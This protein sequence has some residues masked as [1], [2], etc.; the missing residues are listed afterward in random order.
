MS[1]RKYLYAALIAAS[2]SCLPAL[3]QNSVFTFHLPNN[4]VSSIAED[5]DGFIWF[6]TSNGL[7][8]Y[9]GSNCLTFYASSEEYDIHNDNIHALLYDRNNKTLW[10]GS[11]NGLI[12]FKDSRFYNPGTNV[13]NPVIRVQRL[14]NESLIGTG[15]DGIVKISSDGK[16]MGRLYKP[17]MSWITNICVSTIGE[18]WFTYPMNGSIR[19]CV[20][21]KDLH[22]IKEFV[23]ENAD[24]IFCQ[25]SNPD[26]TVWVAT[27]K[28]ILSYNAISRMP[29]KTPETVSSLCKGK[30]IKFISPYG[31]DAVLI[32]IGREGMYLY[33]FHK[34]SLENVYHEQR[35]NAEHY[36]CF[37][38][39]HENIWLSDGK[40]KPLFYP[41]SQQFIHLSIPSAPFGKFQKILFDKEGIMWGCTDG[42]YF[43][44]DPVNGDVLWQTEEKSGYTNC[45]IDSRN[46]LW[47]ISDHNK[48]NRYSISGGLARLKDTYTFQ[49]DISALEE[50]GDGNIWICQ[51]FECALFRS[52]NMDN[53]KLETV[54][55]SGGSYTIPIKDSGS[56]AV[57]LHSIGGDFFK[58]SVNGI[59]QDKSLSDIGDICCLHTAKDGNLWIGTFTNGLVRYNPS[60]SETTRFNTDNGLV[61]SYIKAIVEDPDGNIWF[62]SSK[63]ITKID[64]ASNRLLTLFDNYSGTTATY[65]ANCAGIS[66][67]GTLYFG[68][69][70]G[71]TAVNFKAAFDESNT[72]IPLYFQSITVQGKVLNGIPERIV[73]K[74]NENALSFL[75]SGLQFQTGSLLNY[76][77]KLDGFD[78]DWTY[79]TMLQR[80]YSSLPPGHYTFKVKVRL[81]NGEWSQYELA[82]PVRVK[83]SVWNSLASKIIYVLLF[84]GL[85]LA[86]IHIVTLFNIKNEKIK[87][88]EEKEEISRSHMDFISNISHEIRTPL[89]LI[90]APMKELMKNESLSS[91]DKGLLS[92]MERNAEILKSLS[93]KLL[94]DS[95]QEKKK[96]EPL[97]VASVNLS[98]L[99]LYSTE[100]FKYAAGEKD[101]DIFTNIMEGVSGYADREKVEKILY[102]FLSNALKYTPEHGEIKVS[103]LID[104]NGKAVFS[105]ADNGVGVPEEKRHNLFNRFERLGIE[106]TAPEIEGH[107]IGLNYSSYLARLHKGE[108]SFSPNDPS[109]SVFTLSIPTRKSN[110]SDEEILDFVLKRKKSDMA[111]DKPKDKDA[112]N[113]VIAEDNDDVRIFL[114]EL[115]SPQF[116]VT[117]CSNGVEAIKCISDTIPDLVLCDI[118]M[119]GKDGFAVCREIK[120][121][122]NYS[123]IP[124]ILLTA[125]NDTVTSVNS[126]RAGADSFI[127]KPFDPDYLTATILAL[128]NNR[129][130]LQ[131]KILNLTS[132]SI[133]E[134]E[135]IGSTGLSKQERAFLEKLH[136]V[137]DEHIGDENFSVE[138]LSQELAV[139][140]SSL[141]AKVKALTGS[142]PLS[143]LNTY[144]MNVAMELLQSGDYTVA[145]VADHVGSSTPFNFS[146]D[147]KKHFG[148]TPS[149]VKGV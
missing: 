104:D 70:E 10:I 18:I 46:H 109:G 64:L 73:L 88:A 131:D 6:A 47:T 148:V 11:E 71:M 62:S 81:M 68:T 57:F 4:D 22:Q 107:G 56:G 74:H 48:V 36:V 58:C 118:L 51:S 106:Q 114:R 117:T 122:P 83:P 110:Y 21:D 76:A 78:K 33:D 123:H 138:S 30:D 119:P 40:G 23:L 14:D 120:D 85:L 116:N 136:K 134:K 27:D 146:R 12:Y 96:E 61:D 97:K 53:G 91:H 125:K 59:K 145:E 15:R 142:S 101:I 87:L 111:E 127:Q 102:N 149:S 19:L 44:F 143:Y 41:Y 42:G 79:T 135:S 92:M 103:L 26:N 39:S 132:S 121:N 126:M 66:A 95:P 34:K 93:G 52:E 84:I 100:N 20:A 124:V 37:V 69:E 67:D 32:G 1:L 82:L 24:N 115:L 144:R 65:Q 9:S 77:C 5:S 141:Y 137:V 8:R 98:N 105:V 140:Y 2:T 86:L 113:I 29:I 31:K 55:L 50:D 128:I 72:Q 133:E 108:I 35:L 60:T 94:D 139:S 130:R 17:G 49:H 63:N 13:L 90:Y 80:T 75:Y 16:Y 45:L 99:V 54:S 28:G 129:K 89:S 43:S 38:D 7:S 3:A 112:C 25:S 147:F